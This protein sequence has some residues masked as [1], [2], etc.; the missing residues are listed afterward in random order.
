MALMRLAHEATTAT[1][2]VTCQLAG[3]AHNLAAAKSRAQ[4]DDILYVQLMR[5]TGFQCGPVCGERRFLGKAL[6]R[7]RPSPLSHE[8]M[9]TVRLLART[10]TTAVSA[11]ALVGHAPNAA[12]GPL[13]R[14]LPPVAPPVRHLHRIQVASKSRR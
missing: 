1:G 10:A 3:D 5:P 6:L 13:L 7:L 11:R 4:V 9:S 8:H 14:R 12:L 2:F